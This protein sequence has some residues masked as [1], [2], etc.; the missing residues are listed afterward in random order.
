VQVASMNLAKRLAY[1]VER[2]CIAAGSPLVGCQHSVSSAVKC[3]SVRK[4]TEG[5]N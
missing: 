4:C 2:G 1:H 3:G 5:G